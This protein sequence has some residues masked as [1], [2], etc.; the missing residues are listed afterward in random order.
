MRTIARCPA[1]FRSHASSPARSVIS[2]S[3]SQIRQYHDYF[4]THLPSSSVHPDSRRAG[5]HHALPRNQATPHDPRTTGRSPAAPPQ[6]VGIARDLTVVRIPLKGAKHHFGSAVSRGQRPYNEDTFQAGTIEIPAFAKRQPLSLQR[7]PLREVTGATGESGDPQVFYFGVFD[8]HG[9]SECSEFLRDQLHDYIEAA[10]KQFKLESSLKRKKG[11]VTRFGQ[12]SLSDPFETSTSVNAGRQ[13]LKDIKMAE[14][15]EEPIKT[16]ED[17]GKEPTSGTHSM[18]EVPQSAESIVQIQAEEKVMK[19]EKGLIRAWKELVGGYFR[20]FRP[21]YF[22]EKA[23][24]KGHT[25]D[26]V[27][28]AEQAGEE[29][30]I[31]K[32]AFGIEAVLEYAF[33]R[34]DYDF[35][36][37]QVMKPEDD[38]ASSDRPINEDDILGRPSTTKRIG[39]S[40]RFKGGSTCSIA[41]ISTPTPMPFWHPAS[42]ST[43]V[44]SHVGDT[45]ILLCETATGK[46]VPMTSN[47]HPNHPR[48]A[49]RLRRFAA[50]FVTD[51]F[52]EE[53][54]MGLANTRAFGDINSKRVG[55]SAEP[56][57]VRLEMKPAQYSF[58]VLMSDGVTGPVSDQEVV[59]IV[60]EAKTP[61]QG[62]RDLINFATEVS[63]DGDNCT[64][65]VVRLGGWERRGE[66]GLGSMGT[67]ELRDWRKEEA[68]DPRRG[69]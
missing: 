49:E 1:S 26:E 54:M 19:L 12:S 50:T 32:P 17:G 24:G 16:P 27:E 44:T 52:G 28:D 47:H 33:L 31:L 45:R 68:N 56:E 29:H 48:E 62:A 30:E 65:L 53:R 15:N 25:L 35:T 34:A 57:I 21:E 4:V 5:P 10:A 63:T 14:A 37:A 43:L 36:Y 42:S 64:A 51:S 60:K 40:K 20:R 39:G 67:K 6:T 66:G 59:D 8:G 46:A 2:G 61:E 58:M 13:A 11:E 69:R 41:M 55:V 18:E 7:N 22:A 3:G 9:G 38:G 23:G